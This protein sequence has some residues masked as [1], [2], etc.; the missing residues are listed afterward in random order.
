[1]GGIGGSIVGY[2]QSDNYDGAVL[3]ILKIEGERRKVLI[4]AVGKVLITAGATTQ[5]IE[6]SDEF[7]ECLIQFA[8]QD[9]T[10]DGIW[11][12]CLNSM[13]EE[14]DANRDEIVHSS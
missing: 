7:R 12:A 1:V 9:S 5:Q 10:R 11:K 3:A 13:N 14:P 4:E 2:L 8:Q 6:S